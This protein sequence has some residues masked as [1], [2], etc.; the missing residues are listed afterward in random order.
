ML[1]PQVP[2]QTELNH[3]FFESSPGDINVILNWRP[4]FDP[5]LTKRFSNYSQGQLQPGNT[6]TT[7]KFPAAKGSLLMGFGHPSNK[8]SYGC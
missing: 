8:G 6:E 3:V 2:F 4:R 1:I 5:T 7:R